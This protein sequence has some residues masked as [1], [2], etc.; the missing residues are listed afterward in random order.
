MLN[1]NIIAHIGEE[2]LNIF[3]RCLNDIQTGAVNNR[4][5]V[6]SELR[7]LC[8]CFVLFRLLPDLHQF[9]YTCFNFVLHSRIR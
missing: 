7:I 2:L 8:S 1:E 4:S 3:G 6:S 5:T 9:F